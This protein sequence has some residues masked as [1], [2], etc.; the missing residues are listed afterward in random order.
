MFEIQMDCQSQVKDLFNNL[1]S[2]KEESQVQF[3]NIIGF[4]DKNIKDGISHMAQEVGGLKA[5]LSATVSERNALMENVNKELR[6]LRTQLSVS[7]N[8]RNVLMSTVIPS[9]T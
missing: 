4:Y 2:W 1:N 3:S 7:E 8:Q 6:S 5:Q 9:I